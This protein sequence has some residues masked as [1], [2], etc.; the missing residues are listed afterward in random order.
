MRIRVPEAYGGHPYHAVLGVLRGLR[1]GHEDAS[2]TNH[3]RDQGKH[4]RVEDPAL[5]RA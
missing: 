3:A 5:L 4:D 1:Q 2:L